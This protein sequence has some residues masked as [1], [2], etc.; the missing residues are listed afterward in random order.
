LVFADWNFICGDVEMTRDELEKEF[1]RFVDEGGGNNILE[2]VDWFYSKLQDA[3]AEEKRA[4]LQRVSEHF[5]ECNHPHDWQ[6][7]ILEAIERKS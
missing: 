3:V 5:D 7:C 6:K 4:I 1:R 2:I